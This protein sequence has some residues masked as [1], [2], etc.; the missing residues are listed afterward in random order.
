MV[1]E[2]GGGVTAY[3]GRPTSF[4]QAFG[5]FFL[6]TDVFGTAAQNTVE[7]PDQIRCIGGGKLAETK[8]VTGK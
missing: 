6:L 3:R 5:L 4:F 8:L 2:D 1:S 7:S